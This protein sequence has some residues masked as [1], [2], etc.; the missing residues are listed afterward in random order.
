M[1][2]LWS[3]RSKPCQKMR[4]RRRRFI[5]GYIF[6]RCQNR[7]TKG[8]RGKK[9]S[10]FDSDSFPSYSSGNCW[11]WRIERHQGL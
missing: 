10:C 1:T 11:T 2:G 5:F 6:A 4:F 3:P 9:K 7:S 8:S